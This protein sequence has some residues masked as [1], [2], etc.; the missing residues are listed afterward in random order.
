M[1]LVIAFGVFYMNED[2][3]A[4]TATMVLSDQL[5]KI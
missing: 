3:G 5:N 4:E 1:G 2:L